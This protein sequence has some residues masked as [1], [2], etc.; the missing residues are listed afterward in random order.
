MGELSGQMGLEIVI[1]GADVH[2]LL[3]VEVA[4]PVVVD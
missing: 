3:C 1:C 4:G 2:V